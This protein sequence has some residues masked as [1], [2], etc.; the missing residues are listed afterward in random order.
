M[1][2]D[3]PDVVWE[4][5]NNGDNKIFAKW[6]VK[7]FNVTEKKQIR[8]LLKSDNVFLSQASQFIRNFEKILNTANQTND[9]DKVKNT[10]LKSDLGTIYTTIKKN[11]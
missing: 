8:E 4:K 7:M 3:I 11:I 5:Y 6:L 1:G 2:T 10:I 9:A